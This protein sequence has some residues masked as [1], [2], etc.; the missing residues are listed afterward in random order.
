MSR[1][2]VNEN[3][4]VSHRE[5]AF[6]ID[7]KP[8][9]IYGGEMHFFRVLP[10][11]WAD[12]LLK[13][14]R[15]YLNTV[16]AYVAWNWHEVE[17]GQFDFF[18]PKDLDRFL[19]MAERAGLNIF[20]RPGPFICAEWDYGGL[21]AWLLKE[22]CEVRTTEETYLS[23]VRRWYK[24]VNLILGKH[25]HTRGGGIILYQVENEDWWSDVPY[26]LRLLEMVREDGIDV[27]VT[28]NENPGVRGTE[29]IDTF[30]DYPLP[31]QP[32][33]P[34]MFVPEGV[35]YK[36]EELRKTQPAKPMMYSEFE[37]GWF[38]L[39]GEDGPSARIGEIPP[40]WTDALTKTVIGMGVNAIN[41]Y[42]FCGGTNFAYNQ[43]RP[44]TSSHDWM[45]PV[46]E[47]GQLSPGYYVLRRIGGFIET[48]GQQLAVCQPRYELTEGSG[49]EI[50]VFKRIGERSAFLFPRNIGAA[51]DKRYFRIEIPGSGESLTFPKNSVY[52]L[53]PHCASI[54]PV[55]V[56]LAPDGPGLLYST[57]QLFRAYRNKDELIVMLYERPGFEGELVLDLAFSRADVRITGPARH[58]WLSD[59]RLCLNFTHQESTLIVSIHDKHPIKL[60]LTTPKKAGRTWELP[61]EEGVMPLVSNLY[62][63]RKVEVNDGHIIAEVDVE[64][65]ASIE[66]ELPS[67]KAPHRVLLDGNDIP[68]NFDAG[69]RMSHF[70]WNEDLAPMNETDLGGSWKLKRD[71]LPSLDD[72]AW[73]PYR[74][75]DSAEQSGYYHNGHIWYGTS[76]QA[77]STE[78]PLHLLLTRCQDD[79]TVYVNGWYAG[80]GNQHLEMEISDLVQMGV[81]NTL[82]IC[83]EG[84]GRDSWVGGDDHSG[85]IGPVVLYRDRESIPIT[86]WKR[87]E[88]P[89]CEEYSLKTPPAQA[90]PDYYDANWDDCVIRSGWDSQIHGRWRAKHFLWYRT[91]IDVP[92]TWDGKRIWLEV[93]RAQDTT[94]V[95][96]DGRLAGKVAMFRRAG[97]G[98][99]GVDL[100]TYVRPGRKITLACCV[101]GKW[102]GRKGFHL[103]VRLSAANDLL[104]D[105]WVIRD[106][107]EGQREGM[108]TFE[109][110]DNGWQEVL[111]PGPMMHE[112]KEG[113]GIWWLRKKFHWTIYEGWDVPIGLSLKELNCKALVYLNGHLVGRYH[114]LG[115]QTVFLLPAPWV[116]GDNQLALALD[117][118]CR[119]C[120][121]GEVA[122]LSRFP[123]RRRHLEIEVSD[124]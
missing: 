58:E 101:L 117:T 110:D 43:G 109:C 114:P 42:M 46:G 80:S 11:Q 97:R 122:V 96:V 95:F 32:N 19:A 20:I 40:A 66:I 3:P 45:A 12:R 105:P 107:L 59:K 71:P 74:P 60:I 2:S 112:S 8:V 37:S 39:Y 13:M 83:I 113:C 111:L 16:G 7:G 86:L 18:G 121:I 119:P 91:K 52:E 26:A 77:P 23:F 29:I 49:E 48:L 38:S 118:E 61:L 25:L 82:L 106:Q 124:S 30:D 28:A 116:K 41:N 89:H 120:R 68:V 56:Q 31:W 108:A 54:L 5:G 69:S 10:E 123:V 14:R 67:S 47:W 75:W 92:A 17:P 88:M 63:L 84:Q 21:P 36:L 62:F 33:H 104:K 64:P 115:P 79:A 50:T 103:Y 1:L 27:P 78:G 94:W 51:P 98:E 34:Y 44:S 73:K 22:G 87:R 100:T 102:V 6:L 93:G 57:S 90:L 24:N 4:S 53:G 70:G 99:F 9:F 55:H 65:G 72:A 85:L 35:E 15:C 76:F 81:M